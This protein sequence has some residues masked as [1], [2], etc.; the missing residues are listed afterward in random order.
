MYYKGSRFQLNEKKIS[1]KPKW[2]KAEFKI[3]NKIKYA[4]I[5]LN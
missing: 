4:H 1:Y 5:K 3:K 2:I